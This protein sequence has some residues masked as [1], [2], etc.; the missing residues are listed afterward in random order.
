MRIILFPLIAATLLLTS[1]GRSSDCLT[2]TDIQNYIAA[3]KSMRETA[4]ELLKEVNAEKNA[5]V[6]GKKGYDQME[7]CIKDA[8][9]KDYKTFI[10]LN[11][12]IGA[13][14]FVT[15]NENTIMTFDGMTN[16]ELHKLDSSIRIFDS[17]IADPKVADENK[18]EYRKARRETA[19]AKQYLKASWKNNSK[20]AN[21]VLDRVKNITNVIVPECDLDMVTKHMDEILEAYQGFPI[22][23]K[24]QDDTRYGGWK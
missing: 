21:L 23:G 16:N 11:T 24:E 7:Q 3:Y 14:I 15:Q 10:F 1:C 18:V 19:K 20:W 13:I 2:D 8:G 4:P 12:K 17:L 22:P 6:S 5:N 9:I